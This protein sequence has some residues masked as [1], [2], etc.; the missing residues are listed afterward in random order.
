MNLPKD[1]HS[2]AGSIGEWFLRKLHHYLIAADIDRK[3]ARP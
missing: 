3:G 2:E 1:C